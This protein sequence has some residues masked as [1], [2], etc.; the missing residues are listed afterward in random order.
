MP[1]K[2][3]GLPFVVQPRLKPIMAQ[4]GTEESGIIEIERRGYLTVAEKAMVEQAA[5]EGGDQEALLETVKAIAVE[6]GR[7]VSEIFDEL[8][9]SSRNTALLNKH[10]TLLA[11][12]T[13]NVNAQQ[14]KGRIVSATAL[15]LSRIDS[16]WTVDQTMEMHPDLLDGLYQL[17]VEE[18]N[19]SLEAFADQVATDN[20]KK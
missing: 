8:Q 17:Y 15:I 2:K 16:G 4:I 9:D 10:A 5:L 20:V 1:A 14:Q 18:D 3:K 7:P 6:E 11:Q 19:K 13:T 12:V